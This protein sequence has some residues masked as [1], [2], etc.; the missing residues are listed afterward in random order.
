MKNGIFALFALLSLPLGGCATFFE[1]GDTDRDPASADRGYTEEDENEGNGR[2]CA[3]R[4]CGNEEEDDEA[5]ASSRSAPEANVGK[6]VRRAI[7]ARDIVLGM[8]RQEVA[9]SWGEPYMREAAGDGSIG[10]ERW[11]YGSRYSLSKNKTIIFEN[12][13]VA[14]WLR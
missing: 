10:H 2:S 4:F 12:G 13:R 9:E 5:A 1:L 8:T 6:R 7:Q 3:G 14:G 11:T